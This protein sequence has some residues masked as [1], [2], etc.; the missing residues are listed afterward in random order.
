MWFSP[1]ALL[2]TLV[3]AA[4]STDDRRSDL[5]K[6]VARYAGPLG[7]EWDQ[8]ATKVAWVDL[9]EDGLDDAVI[10]LTGADWCG[11]DGCT[12][13]VFEQMN[14]L[15]AEEFGRFRP[16]AEIRMITGPIMVVRGHGYWSDLVVTSARGPRRLHFN[17]E[18]Y[19]PSPADGD[20]VQGRMP[21]GAILF[22]DR[23]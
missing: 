20:R 23:P 15:D 3:F 18:T 12:V 21:R 17:G 8:A 22:A 4:D 10:S 6:A 14:P 7:L 19:P 5:D 1:L 13:L 9:N 16:A 2:L 11:P